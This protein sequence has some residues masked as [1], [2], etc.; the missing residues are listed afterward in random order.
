MAIA[1]DAPGLR[2]SLL[3]LDLAAKFDH[4]LNRDAEEFGC[5]KRQPRLPGEHLLDDQALAEF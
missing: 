1:Q 3:Y 4:P 5:I 2:R